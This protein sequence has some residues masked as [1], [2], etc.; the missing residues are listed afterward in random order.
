MEVYVVRHTQ[1][2][3][4]KN[5]CYGQYDV[6]LADTSTQEAAALKAKLPQDFDAVFSSPLSRCTKLAE[7]IVNQEI[8]LSPAL[9]EM[10]FGDWENKA[11]NDINQQE[12]TVWMDDF[13]NVHPPNGENLITVYQRLSA[14]LN[15]LRNKPYKKILIVT[16]AGI[17]RCCWAYLLG[18]PLQ[19]IFKITVGYGEVLTFNLAENP[20]FDS[21]KKL[22]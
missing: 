21:I 12:L 5:T 14:F 13:V 4:A 8:V 3:V 15:Q 6:N 16:H 10:N 17:I 1:V 2:N 7:T 11:W 18:I 19:N 22:S 20:A 9:L